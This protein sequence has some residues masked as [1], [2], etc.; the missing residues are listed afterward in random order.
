MYAIRSYYERI[1]N[2]TWESNVFDE[3]MQPQLKKLQ[4]LLSKE[5][6]PVQIAEPKNYSYNFV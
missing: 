5:Q 1:L 6:E 2:T 4:I 3:Q